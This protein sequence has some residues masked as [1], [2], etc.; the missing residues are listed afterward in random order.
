VGRLPQDQGQNQA[1]HPLP[2]GGQPPQAAQTPRKAPQNFAAFMNPPF[3]K[4]PI[5]EL[6]AESDFNSLPSP[7][8]NKLILW[9]L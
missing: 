1:A 9:D 8:S 3:E 4:V 7:D 5:R 2:D 6:L